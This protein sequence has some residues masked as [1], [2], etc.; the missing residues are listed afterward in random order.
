MAYEAGLKK[1]HTRTKPR[2][3]SGHGASGGKANA[4]TPRRSIDGHGCLGE[5]RERTLSD[6]DLRKASSKQRSQDAQLKEEL[7]CSEEMWGGKGEY[8]RQDKGKL[9]VAP[10]DALGATCALMRDTSECSSNLEEAIA[11][12]ELG[13]H[14]TLNLMKERIRACLDRGGKRLVMCGILGSVSWHDTFS[15]MRDFSMNWSPLK[16]LVLDDNQ[17]DSGPPPEALAELGITNLERLR[18]GENCLRALPDGVGKQLVQLKELDLSS[19]LFTCL[20]DVSTLPQGLVKL[21]LHDNELQV[22]DL[23]D[24]LARRGMLQQLQVLDLSFNNIAHLPDSISELKALV[25]LT[26]ANNLIESLP[27]AISRSYMPALSELDVSQN[28]LTEPPLEIAQGPKNLEKIERYFELQQQEGTELIANQLKIIFIGNV[29]AGKSSVIECMQSGQSSNIGVDERTLGINIHTWTPVLHHRKDL[30]HKEVQGERKL[31]LWDF[32]GQHVYHAIHGLFFSKRALYLL[33]FDVTQ[34]SKDDIDRHVQFW[35]DCVQSRA[36][37]AQIQ[38]VGTH[39]D[40]L[41]SKEDLQ[42]RCKQVLDQLAENE[43]IIVQSLKAKKAAVLSNPNGNGSPGLARVLRRLLLNRPRIQSEI[44]TVSCKEYKGFKKLHKKI[45]S[46]TGDTKLFPNDKV[47]VSWKR[48]HERVEELREQGKNL[49]GLGEFMWSPTCNIKAVQ[50]VLA[51]LN[52]VSELVYFNKP[53]L[54]T[55]IFLHPRR[56]LEAIKL[57]VRHDLEE[58]VQQLVDNAAGDDPSRHT[59]EVSAQGFSRSASAN[60]LKKR[61]FLRR[62]KTGSLSGSRGSSAV[63]N[64]RTMGMLDEAIIEALLLPVREDLDPDADLKGFLVELMR[65]FGVLLKVASPREVVRQDQLGE[66]DEE[67]QCYIVPCL[68]KEEPIAWSFAMVHNVTSGIVWRFQRFVPP[69]LMSC[70]I[71]RLYSL[72][73]SHFIRLSTIYMRVSLAPDEDQGRGKGREAEVLVRLN[74]LTRKGRQETRLEMWAQTRVSYFEELMETLEGCEGVIEQTLSEYPGVLVERSA[75]CPLCIENRPTQ[76]E[77]W[78][79]FPLENVEDNRGSPESI[80]FCDQGCK[81]L[82]LYQRLL[83]TGKLEQEELDHAH[84]DPHVSDVVQSRKLQGCKHMYTAVCTIGVYDLDQE[85]IKQQATA[86]IVDG[87]RGVL[88]TAAHTF[89]NW[90]LDTQE[91]NFLSEADQSGKN[92]RCVILVGRYR[93]EEK[94]HWQYVAEALVNWEFAAALLAIPMMKDFPV[95]LKLRQTFDP[96]DSRVRH[97]IPFKGLREIIG[98]A[99]VDQSDLIISHL[100]PREMRQLAKE[101]N[102]GLGLKAIKLGDSMCYAANGELQMNVSVEQELTLIA[103]PEHILGSSISVTRGKVTRF[104]KQYD[105]LEISISNCPGGSGGPFLNNRG[106]CVGFL[107]HGTDEIAWALGAMTVKWYDSLPCIPSPPTSSSWPLSLSP[108]HAN[109]RLLKG[110]NL[111]QV[112]DVIPMAEEGKEGASED[113]LE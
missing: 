49:V 57:V 30:P 87:D 76:I 95:V 22:L 25:K 1:L 60:S 89:I 44:T 112:Y 79:C 35:I 68:L 26:A 47:P 3:G 27:R 90:C 32:G 46:L 106:E 82:K 20:P 73:F 65:K 42:E 33:V 38:L 23:P 28:P 55:Y 104:F 14:R 84:Q 36:P 86:F 91:W 62:G 5:M 111:V 51:W 31:K 93:S 108:L 69:G 105:A 17:L 67:H 58:Q 109:E 78:A 43:K 56:L 81:L 18:L 96:V 98:R 71:S 97:N 94:A 107:S 70:L 66:C 10:D 64:L 77:S 75:V 21:K 24:G 63:T 7:G 4:H 54:D 15:L 80:A 34:T 19:N 61:E 16:N 101:P 110:S 99:P 12:A 41:P 53:G 74:T 48:A 113:V 59:A 83:F 52:D 92:N 50:E 100:R 88:I 11:V 39:V 72:G 37:G 8:E 40:L 45:V 29:L 103:W 9:V 2:W 13:Q 6:K 102:P 85:K